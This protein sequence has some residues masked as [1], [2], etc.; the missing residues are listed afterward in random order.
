MKVLTLLYTLLLA[1]GMSAQNNSD[2]MLHLDIFSFEK[3]VTLPG[4][5][6]Q[7]F[8]DEATGDIS[9][10]WDHFIFERVKPYVEARN[11]KK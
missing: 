7:I 3:T 2:Q 6:F 11:S 1:I 4:T 5:V 9:G 10:F 8:D